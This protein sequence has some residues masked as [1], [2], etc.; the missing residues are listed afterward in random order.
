MGINSPTLMLIDLIMEV[1]YNRNASLALDADLALLLDEELT[2][3]SESRLS[4]NAELIDSHLKLKCD[5]TQACIEV[6]A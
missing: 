5:A 3:F 4:W 2:G 6:E 1:S